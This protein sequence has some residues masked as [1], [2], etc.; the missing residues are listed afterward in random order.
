MF[1][2]QDLDCDNVAL[3][4]TTVAGNVT[5][6]ST[7][8]VTVLDDVIAGFDGAATTSTGTVQI[9]AAVDLL[10]HDTVVSDS[11][12]IILRADNDVR[13][14]VAPVP[15]LD[16]LVVVTTATGRIEIS[17]DFN[18]DSNG[19]GGELFMSDQARVVAGRG[20]VGYIPGIDGNP[21][22]STIALSTH[23]HRWGYR[24]DEC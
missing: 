7:G 3:S 9:S 17:A 2:L 22:P 5:L 15:E 23:C 11:G 19:A 6:T 8:N 14:A 18:N 24:D 12:N 1:R 13:I 4:T 20:N 16:D 10:V 21:S